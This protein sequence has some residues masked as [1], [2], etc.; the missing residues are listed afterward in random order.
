MTVVGCTGHQNIPIGAMPYVR[1]GI[2]RELARYSS[3]S[4]VGVCSLAAGADQLF[5]Q[6]VLDVGGNLEVVIPAHGYE[7]TFD[8]EGARRFHELMRRATGSETLQWAEPSE[9]AYLAAGHLI[10]D[11]AN[12]LLAVWDGEQSRGKGGTG[13]IV[14]YAQ[15][16]RVPTIVIWPAGV[17]R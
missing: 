13:D 9:D 11:R 16:R 5:A 4:F 15:E 12:V 14:H 17:E 8:S 1:D 3:A 2:E 7:S 10:V 6:L